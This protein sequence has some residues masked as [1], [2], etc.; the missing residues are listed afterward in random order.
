MP[1]AANLE[2]ARIAVDHDGAPVGASAHVLDTHGRTSRQEA[3]GCFPRKRTGEPDTQRQ[4]AVRDEAI[5]DTPACAELARRGPE[6]LLDGAVELP[7]AAETRGERDLGHGEIGI[8]EEP[9]SEVGAAGAP[10]LRGRHA[11]LILEETA[12]VSRRQPEPRGDGSFARHV[13]TPTH[14]EPDAPAHEL[15]RGGSGCRGLSVR[16]A[17]QARAIAGSLGG[18]GKLEMPDVRWIRAR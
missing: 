18:G 6:D 8:V 1:A 16:T 10:Q 14:H 7:Q 4:A 15:G 13:D 9:A 3:E 5:G 17:A 11:D 12:E 2:G